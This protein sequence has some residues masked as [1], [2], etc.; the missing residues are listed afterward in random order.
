MRIPHSLDEQ[1]RKIS[2]NGSVTNLKKTEFPASSI[3]LSEEVIRFLI[4]KSSEAI[5]DPEIAKQVITEKQAKQYIE[6]FKTKRSDSKEY[7]EA[8][9]FLKTYFD[10]SN[11]IDIDL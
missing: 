3:S 8:V 10:P 7:S 11:K 1:T 9:N 4:D 2:G 6:N 5:N